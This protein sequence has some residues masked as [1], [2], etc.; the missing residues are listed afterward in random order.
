MIK[1]LFENYGEIGYAGAIIIAMIWYFYYQTKCQ[2]K[3]ED[4]HDSIQKEERLFYRT[5]V[6]NDM[7][8]LHQDNVKN[9]DLNNQSISLIKDI[10]KNL[11]EHNGHS[12]KAWDK[13]I[14]SLDII[15]DRLNGGSPASKAIKKELE[16][17]RNSDRRK[18]DVSVKLERRG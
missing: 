15:A 4:K 6:T 11:E 12:Q 5:L 3:R 18:K 7:K 9:A 13:T 16:M 10:N 2:S 17:Y 8:E 14:S 1:T